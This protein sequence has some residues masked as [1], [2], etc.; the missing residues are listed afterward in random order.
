MQ[1]GGGYSRFVAWAKVVLP[2]VALALLATLFL[3]ARRIDP[4]A[5]IPFAEV[6]VEQYAREARIGA[7]E[8]SG[9]TAD[10]TVVSLSADLARPDP[11]MPSRMLADGLSARLEIPDGSTVMLEAATGAVD[12]VARSI[13]LGGGVTIATSTGYRIETTDLAAD[14]G[15]TGLRADGAV[16][17]SGPPGRLEAGAMALT[18][19]AD[20]EGEYLLVF[21]G[22]VKLVYDPGD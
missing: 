5:A 9:V 3:I 10:G 22:G 14:M 20:A 19:A 2:L 16:V 15:E 4:D 8:F 1:A 13:T 6:D 21:S 18:R 17:A 7:P 12:G 11:A